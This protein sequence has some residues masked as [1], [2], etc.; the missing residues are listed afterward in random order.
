[1]FQDGRRT[2]SSVSEESTNGLFKSRDT[3][4][5]P[6]RS[7]KPKEVKMGN[8]KGEDNITSLEDVE[9]RL[10]ALKKKEME[11]KMMELQQREREHALRL[12]EA[13]AR[14]EQLRLRTTA[15]TVGQVPPLNVAGFVS[16]Y[17][18]QIM[19]GGVGPRIKGGLPPRPAVGLPVRP[20]SGL[21]STTVPQFNYVN[22]TVSAP[23][24]AN[25][26]VPAVS[27]PPNRQSNTKPPPVKPLAPPATSLVR[28]VHPQAA[29]LPTGDT[30]KV[31]KNTTSTFPDLDDLPKNDS[32]KW[33]LDTL[34]YNEYQ[35]KFNARDQDAFEKFKDEFP[36]IEICAQKSL[37]LSPSE[38]RFGQAQIKNDVG[39]P[40]DQLRI[41]Q[42]SLDLDNESL[43]NFLAKKLT[44]GLRLFKDNGQWYSLDN[45]PLAIFKLRDMHRIEKK[46][47]KISCV[48]VDLAKE[49]G[50]RNTV[51]NT[52]NTI[53]QGRTVEVKGTDCV[54]GN[55][56]E[57]T[58][59]TV[60]K[61]TS[62]G[63]CGVKGRENREVEKRESQR[64]RSRDSWSI[65]SADGE[66]EHISASISASTYEVAPLSDAHKELARKQQANAN[67]E[68][69]EPVPKRLSKKEKR[70][71]KRA[72]AEEMNQ[73]AKLLM[74]SAKALVDK[75][76]NGVTPIDLDDD[77]EEDKRRPDG[78]SDDDMGIPESEA[79][80]GYVSLFDS[81]DRHS[82]DDWGPGN[83]SDNESD[84][85]SVGSDDASESSDCEI[86][87][88]LKNMDIAALTRKQKKTYV[89]LKML[90]KRFL[91]RS[92]EEEKAH[93][94][95]MKDIK[96]AQER[97]KLKKAKGKDG[98]KGK[99]KIKDRTITRT[100]AKGN[101]IKGGGKGK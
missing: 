16:G 81:K 97:N 77:I 40:S 84:K 20:P 79:P 76:Y 4:P 48:Q 19:K 35:K 2:K 68:R 28:K 101:P 85:K 54:I 64:K 62:I 71:A 58:T 94:E 26:I 92:P 6:K 93:E 59:L 50:D 24:R 45:T 43:D 7:L 69:S 34:S 42:H 44:K 49:K 63:N 60:G 9:A 57:E 17:P 30:S 86:H 41:D 90:P 65:S 83:I 100:D 56:L 13:Q 10:E 74:T 23:V 8:F 52:Y 22:T 80:T 32:S 53:N 33:K 25:L 3:D 95:H 78:L 5:K 1:M 61:E 89:K 11:L 15:I 73:S 55:T 31:A 88:D 37:T 29:K 27:Q 72:K 75:N 14:E 70:A 87:E 99:G 67:N 39:K 96:L 51:M 91:I 12:Q 47:I 46:P 21:V 66:F 82:D 18:N 36:K 98:G 38:I